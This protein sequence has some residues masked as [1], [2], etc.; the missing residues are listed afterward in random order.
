MI[1]TMHRPIYSVGLLD[2]F[3]TLY[4]ICMDPDSFCVV[5]RLPFPSLAGS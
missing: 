2:T 1:L 3:L 5:V 4:I